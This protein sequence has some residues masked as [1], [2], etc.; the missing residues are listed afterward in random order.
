MKNITLL[1]LLTLL[2]AF[3]FSSPEAE[4][5]PAPDNYGPNLNGADV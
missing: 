2:A 3:V 1:L 5:G 4:A